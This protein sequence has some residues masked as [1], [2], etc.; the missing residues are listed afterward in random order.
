LQASSF[1][2]SNFSLK[3]FSFSP[4]FDQ[5]LKGR[6]LMER[7]SDYRSVAVIGGQSS[8]KSMKL[9]LESIYTISCHF[10][11]STFLFYRYFTKHTIRNDLP[12]HGRG[13]WY[14]TNDEGHLDVS[15]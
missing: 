1:E 8:G 15:Q 3:A 4:T 14:L 7:G 5:Y 12:G 10:C 2:Y 11:C 6:N 13:H 9:T